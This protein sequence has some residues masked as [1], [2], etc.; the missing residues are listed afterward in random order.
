MI[1]KYGQDSNYIT[2]LREA[3]IAT[4]EHIQHLIDLGII[5]SRKDIH[6]CYISTLY[7]G[8]F[9]V[10]HIDAGSKFHER[11]QVPL[12]VA[13]KM[14]VDGDTFTVEEPYRLEHWKPHAVWNSDLTK[15][16]HIVVDK[17]NIVYKPEVS[18]KMKVVDFVIPELETL[19]K[20]A[21]S[22]GEDS[23]ND[24]KSLPDHG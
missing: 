21:M 8:G 1:S 3:T 7:P 10:P 23:Q 14:W 2:H 15:R 12:Q 9:I 4:T 19:K 17:V 16:V 24:I 18:V 22:Q 20:L 13:G 11:W 6:Y 5:N